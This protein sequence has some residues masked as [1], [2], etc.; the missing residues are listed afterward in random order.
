MLRPSTVL[1]VA[2]GILVASGPSA[3]ADGWGSV[4]CDHA[5]TPQCQL[6][7]GEQATTRPQRPASSAGSRPSEGASRP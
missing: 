1:G 4:D 7:A 6:E 3:G 5:S 2:V